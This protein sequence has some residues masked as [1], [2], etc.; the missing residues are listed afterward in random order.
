MFQPLVDELR[1]QGGNLR[2]PSILADGLME[3]DPTACKRAGVSS[4]K[5]YIDRAVDAGIVTVGT[6]EYPDRP[7]APWIS[8][9]LAWRIPQNSDTTTTS[10]EDGSRPP[11]SLSAN[12][13]LL[14]VAP[15]APETTCQAGTSANDAD[16]APGANVHPV[17][18]H[19]TAIF[20]ALVDELRFQGGNLRQRSIVADGLLKR[21]PIAYK[22]A[23]VSGFKGYIDMAVE[24][25]IVTVGTMEYPDR[26]P[27]PWISLSIAWRLPQES[28]TA[29]QSSAAVSRSPSSLEATSA[30]PQARSLF[31]GLI[32][33]L[34]QLSTRPLRSQVAAGL[35]KRDP[36]A[37]TRAGVVSF[38][39][40]IG[41]PQKRGGQSD[42]HHSS[43]FCLEAFYSGTIQTLPAS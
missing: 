7:A 34:R 2:Q 18:P 1:H 31:Q 26:L 33:E 24:A 22:R 37:Y 19:P 6:M 20:Q 30:A 38:G 21:D 27:D 4:F 10:S 8:L 25:G 17:P 40:Y 36:S 11:S 28:V 9:N 35:L 42:N 29:I 32:D 41:K 15:V 3:R 5:D 39:H 16:M 43:H 23:G 13:H 12:T 14:A